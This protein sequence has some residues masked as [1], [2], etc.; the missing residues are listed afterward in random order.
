MVAGPHY[1]AL[2]QT[3]QK[4][5]HPAVLLLLNDLAI[6]MGHVENSTFHSYSI[7]ACYT[8]VT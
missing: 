2:S 3:P 7:E 8:A 6:G 1:I 5:S 4:T